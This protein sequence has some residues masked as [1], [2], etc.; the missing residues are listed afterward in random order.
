MSGDRGRKRTVVLVDDQ[1]EFLELMRRRLALS[2]ALDVVAEATSGEAALALVGELHP[3]PDVVLLDVEMPGLDGFETA[4]RMRNLV[5]GARIVLTS[6]SDSTHYARA[7]VGLGAAFVPKRRL[8]G[9]A[10]LEL[11]D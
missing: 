3:E 1:S 4:R 7:A 2:S 8:S 5:P 6:A 9:E 11:L 10:L